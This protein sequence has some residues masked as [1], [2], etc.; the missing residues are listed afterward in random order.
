MLLTHPEHKNSG[1]STD[2]KIMHIANCRK[3]I[4]NKHK[5]IYPNI[6]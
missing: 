3:K 1:E 5:P 4:T 2:L 6:R